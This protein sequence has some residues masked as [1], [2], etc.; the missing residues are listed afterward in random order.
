M[1]CGRHR[2]P[3]FIPH[4]AHHGYWLTSPFHVEY[5]C[6]T[7]NW[8]I[9]SLCN[10]I[11]LCFWRLW[12]GIWVE[13]LLD[14]IDARWTT[15]SPANSATPPLQVEVHIS[16]TASIT[17][18]CF[19]NPSWQSWRPLSW[20]E[21]SSSLTPCHFTCTVKHPSPNQKNTLL[22]NW[23]FVRKIMMP[24]FSGPYRPIPQSRNGTGILL[25][26]NNILLPDDLLPDLLVWWNYNKNCARGSWFAGA[27]FPAQCH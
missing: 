11:M 4:V 16:K 8:R 26:I 5:L 27:R 24:E 13:I 19:T 1:D 25:V 14:I 21:L 2:T 3:P 18:L 10:C 15:P 7:R 20:H 9:T 17:I 12:V 6:C 22:K 23:K